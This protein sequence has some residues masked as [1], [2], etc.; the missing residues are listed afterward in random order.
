MAMGCANRIYTWI[1]LQA[2]LG[3]GDCKS[4]LG[5]YKIPVAFIS[6]RPMLNGSATIENKSWG[7]AV[8]GQRG[9]IDGPPVQ[10][11]RLRTKRK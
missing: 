4:S 3:M 8:T 11:P 10:I 1:V 6:D 9:R 2:G 5:E 7:S